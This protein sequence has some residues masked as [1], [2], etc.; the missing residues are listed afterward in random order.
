MM[1]KGIAIINTSKILSC[2]NSKKE[3]AIIK[4]IALTNG[5]K[6][7]L[8]DKLLKKGSTSL[9]LMKY[10]DHSTKNRSINL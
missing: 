8:I 9:L 4:Q 7:K 3:N 6:T 1:H 10:I 2:N 5:Y